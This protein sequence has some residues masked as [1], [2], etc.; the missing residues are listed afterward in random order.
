[1]VRRGMFMGIGARGTPT[2]R[3]DGRSPLPTRGRES[4]SRGALYAEAAVGSPSPLWG[5]GTTRSV[6]GGGGDPDHSELHLH[7]SGPTK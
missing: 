7:N 3:P 2:H 1:M 6:V 4:K 5:G